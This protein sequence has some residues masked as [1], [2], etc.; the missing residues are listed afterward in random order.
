MGLVGAGRRQRFI[1]GVVGL[2][3]IVGVSLLNELVFRTWL[4]TDYFRWYLA[5]GALISIVF[6]FVTLAWG[7]LN[8][9]TTLISAHP[10]EYLAA[11]VRLGALPPLAWSTMLNPETRNTWRERGRMRRAQAELQR[12][13]QELLADPA[14]SDE[15]TSRIVA[16]APQAAGV[17]PATPGSDVEGED[18]TGL[19][20]DFLFTAV[21]AFAFVIAYVI[22]LV[23]VVPIQYFVYLVAGAPARE[24]ISSG[25]RVWYRISPREIHIEEAWK[26]DTM[27]DDATESGFFQ[28]PVGFT[29]TVAAAVLFTVSRVL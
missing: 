24:A 10:V 28:R 18:P 19:W 14:L 6:G 21:I 7:D 13:Q 26:T 9:M 16:G 2:G 27:P 8:K 1:S 25:A 5:N 3:F 4:A 22:W 23:V 17:D 29:A 11:W 15:L 12:Q 20:V